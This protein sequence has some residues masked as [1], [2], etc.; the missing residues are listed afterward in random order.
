M[1]CCG[2][3]K[4]ILTIDR[5]LSTTTSVPRVAPAPKDGSM[6]VVAGFTGQLILPGGRNAGPVYPGVMVRASLQ[7]AKDP[8]L[9]PLN[10]HSAKAVKAMLWPTVSAS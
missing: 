2:G 3:E 8:R 4:R 1:G 10:S 5:E 9:V 6:Y 7:E